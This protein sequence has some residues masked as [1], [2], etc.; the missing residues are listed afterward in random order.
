MMTSLIPKER[1]RASVISSSVRPL[2]STR[3]LGRVSVSGRRRVPRPA[4]RIIAFI[5]EPAASGGWRVIR[6]FGEITHHGVQHAQL[7]EFEVADA[8]FNAAAAAQMFCELFGEI[9]GAV[10]AAG[11]AEAHH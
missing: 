6:S 1:R 10:L 7:F 8:D 4:A 2:I 5:R 11:A 9:D 3:A